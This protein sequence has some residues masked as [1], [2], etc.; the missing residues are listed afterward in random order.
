M[1][2]IVLFVATS[3]DGFI[4][5]KEGDTSW[6]FTEGDFG[7]QAFYN[8]IDTTLMGFNTYEFISRFEEFP[9]LGKKNYVFTRKKREVGNHPVEFVFGDV[10]GFTREL[11]EKPGKNIW[12]VGGGQIN[13]LLLNANLID[14]MIISIHPTALGD[15]IKLFRNESPKHFNFRLS[16]HEV[17]E[18]GLVQLTY[19]NGKM[20]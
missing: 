15:G 4:A 5:G 1:R 18:R 7:Y 10:V 6:L 17:F 19:E 13:S 9:Y 11:K 2:K 12:L 14:Q 3:I 20:N 16:K 8:S